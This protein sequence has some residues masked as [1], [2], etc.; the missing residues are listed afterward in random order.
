LALLFLFWGIR[1][2]FPQVLVT[3]GFFVPQNGTLLFLLN[4]T[5]PNH[6]VHLRY[7]RTTAPKPGYDGAIGDVFGDMIASK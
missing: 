4:S 5:A 7:N 6:P 1:I 2:S 3:G